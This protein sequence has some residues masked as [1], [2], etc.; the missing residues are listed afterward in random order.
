MPPDPP[1]G[2]PR[3]PALF[4]VLAVIVALGIIAVVLVVHSG[5]GSPKQKPSPGS[6]SRPA[7]PSPGIPTALPT[8]LP[9][10]L[11]SSLP[12]TL[13]SGFPS[14]L[15]SGFPTAVPSGIES[16]FADLAATP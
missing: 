13:P 6:T 3:R 16:L 8:A 9:S 14:A 12:T 4:L 10:R 2:R 11:P 15:P 5:D 1:S 7:A